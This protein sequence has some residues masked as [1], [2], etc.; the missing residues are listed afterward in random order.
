[1]KILVINGPN[2]NLLGEREPQVYGSVTLDGIKKDLRKY[3]ENLGVTVDFF[4]SNH[5]GD[6][7]D[8]IQEARISA[9][10]LIIN[11]GALTHYSYALR[12]AVA[13]IDKPVIEVHLT[14]IYK[15]EEF[16]HHSVTAGV[17]MGQIS[18]LG[19]QGYKLAL[20]A[21]AA[22]ENTKV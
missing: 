13:A 8:A 22:E 21:L 17:V 20:A 1:M 4:Q 6:L 5:E 3:A 19:P 2:L 18:G 12:D 7:I 15:R 11:P 16:R 10:A 9:D 14:N